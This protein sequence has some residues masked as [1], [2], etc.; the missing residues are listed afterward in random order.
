MSLN[1]KIK[2]VSSKLTQLPQRVQTCH[3]VA[4]I[5][6]ETNQKLTQSNS[7]WKLLAPTEYDRARNRVIST[8]W[9]ATFE[10]DSIRRNSLSTDA[11]RVT[12]VIKSIMNCCEKC[13]TEN[14]NNLS[15]DKPFCC[16]LEKAQLNHQ[17]ETFR[18]TLDEKGQIIEQN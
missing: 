1:D 18:F 12:P 14:Q 11:I 9:S 15:L 16:L 4:Q 3:E 5:L 17:T 2:S 10:L 13:L 8:C 6:I 7:I